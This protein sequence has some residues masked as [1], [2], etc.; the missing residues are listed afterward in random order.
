MQGFREGRFQVLVATDVA[1]RGLDIP[2]VDLVI[3]CEP[4]K[5]RIEG[6][7][8]RGREGER[9]EGGREGEGGRERDGG[10]DNRI[11]G[12]EKEGEGEEREGEKESKRGEN[13]ALFINLMLVPSRVNNK[14]GKRVSN[15]L[16]TPCNMFSASNVTF[17]RA[18]VTSSRG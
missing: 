11:R 9:K 17:S 8:G 4:P 18:H 5:V 3:Q 15:A 1:A 14:E 2:E 7:R 12:G 16:Y 13:V 6:W 10:G